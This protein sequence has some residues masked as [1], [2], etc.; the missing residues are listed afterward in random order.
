MGDFPSSFLIHV[1]K[2]MLLLSHITNPLCYFFVLDGTI[3]LL[4]H[5][6]RVD[7]GGKLGGAGRSAAQQKTKVQDEFLHHA[8]RISW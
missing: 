8:A 5:S 1:V 7:R 2:V 3:H 6:L 4:V